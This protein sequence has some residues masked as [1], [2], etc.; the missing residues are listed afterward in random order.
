M[1]LDKRVGHSGVCIVQFCSVVSSMFVNSVAFYICIRILY[2]VCSCF[3]RALRRF[4]LLVLK[5]LHF[6]VMRSFSRLHIRFRVKG[7][8]QSAWLRIKLDCAIDDAL[9]SA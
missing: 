5:V 4:S 1:K 8:H 2:G 9:G 7:L 3:S 6:H